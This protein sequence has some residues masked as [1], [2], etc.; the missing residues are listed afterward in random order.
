MVLSESCEPH[1]RLKK[2]TIARSTHIGEMRMRNGFL[3][4]LRCILRIPP[5]IFTTVLVLQSFLEFIIQATISFQT[6]LSRND[7]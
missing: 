4:P 5:L 6:H 7:E 2:A 3:H 1:K